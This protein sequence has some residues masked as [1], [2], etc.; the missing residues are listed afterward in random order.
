LE[1]Q[2]Q[3]DGKGLAASKRLNRP[4]RSTP[5]PS[6]RQAIIVFRSPETAKN[7]RLVSYALQDSS[8]FDLT[9]RAAVESGRELRT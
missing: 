5:R 8:M 2:N 7:K 6:S 4:A 9:S 1:E 3:N